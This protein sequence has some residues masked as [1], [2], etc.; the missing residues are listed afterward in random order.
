MSISKKKSPVNRKNTPK[1]YGKHAV[2]KN[3]TKFKEIEQE[4]TTAQPVIL[5]GK[6]KEN[7]KELSENVKNSLYPQNDVEKT[8]VNQIVY[9][10]WKLERL[11]VITQEVYEVYTDMDGG[12]RWCDLL[13]TNYLKKFVRYEQNINNYL[14]ELIYRFKDRPV[15]TLPE[16]GKSLN[17]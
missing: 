1:A 11:E 8:L 17:C 7:F 15:L 9:S 2:T 3:F 5:S 4:M 6:D 10:L 16:K 13:K 14:L 12:I